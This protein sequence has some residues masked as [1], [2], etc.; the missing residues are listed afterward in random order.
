MAAAPYPA[1]RLCAKYPGCFY[2]PDKVFTPPSGIY[3]LFCR[4]SAAPYPANV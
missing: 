3:A 1:Y 4:M 2:R